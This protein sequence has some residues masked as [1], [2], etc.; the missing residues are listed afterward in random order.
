[1]AG[2]AAR[3]NS[4]RVS[5]G[6]DG[7]STLVV[8]IVYTFLSIAGRLRRASS[9]GNN[10]VDRERNGFNGMQV[11]ATQGWCDQTQ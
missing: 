5:W 7:W 4:S 1:M 10:V 9:V 8:Q 6:S 2:H 3:A 11:G